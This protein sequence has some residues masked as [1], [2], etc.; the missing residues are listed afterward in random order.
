MYVPLYFSLT[1]QVNLN[2]VNDNCPYLNV[3]EYYVHGVPPMSVYPYLK[4]NATDADN[5]VNAELVYRRTT[6]QLE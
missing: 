2:D 5:S 4:L 1:V 6:P 3:T